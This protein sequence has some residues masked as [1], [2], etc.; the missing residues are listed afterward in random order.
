MLLLDMIIMFL[1]LLLHCF[2]MTS[3]LKGI[4]KSDPYTPMYRASNR[5]PVIHAHVYVH[6]YVC[7][8]TILASTDTLHSNRC[9]YTCIDTDMTK[10]SCKQLLYQCTCITGYQNRMSLSLSMTVIVQHPVEA[11]VCL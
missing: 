3:I 9:T 2:T 1:L 10:T 4:V 5:Q 8:Y 7:Q 6:N 11:V